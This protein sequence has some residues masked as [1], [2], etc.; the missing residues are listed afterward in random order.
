MMNDRELDAVIANG[1]PSVA[2][3][4]CVWACRDALIEELREDPRGGR[5]LIALIQS[6]LLAAGLNN[7]EPE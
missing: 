4:A 1:S 3:R 6:A 5:E 2:L 7:G